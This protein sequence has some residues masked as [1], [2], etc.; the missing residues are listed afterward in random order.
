MPAVLRLSVRVCPIRHT[1][2]LP[3]TFSTM[4]RARWPD[5]DVLPPC[6]LCECTLH[7]S[8][9]LSAVLPALAVP[10]TTVASALPP[11]I[12]PARS[13]FIWRPLGGGE[14]RHECVC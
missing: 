13:C 3:G 1:F 11:C 9:P 12:S 10:L 6:R 7:T 14:L 8:A 5:P 2:E 4:G